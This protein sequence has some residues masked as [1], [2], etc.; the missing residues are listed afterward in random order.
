VDVF[1]RCVGYGSSNILCFIAP[2]LAALV[3]SN[4]YLQDKNSNFLKFLYTRMDKKRYIIVRII[5][6]ALSSRI[7]IVT[8]LIIL[9]MIITLLLGFKT[10]PNSLFKITGL[11]SFLYYKSKWLYVIYFIMNSFIFNV[12]FATL[13]LGLSPFI[14]N[15]YL[16]FLCPFALYTL[17]M[18]LLSYIG[19]SFLNMGL[20]FLSNTAR[21]E[22]FIIT[23]QSILLIIGITLFYLGVLY[24]NEKNL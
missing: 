14:N 12:I 17:S 19:L 24:R 16:S 9:L 23:Y 6:N 10:N 22:I 11:F 1:L 15:K 13:A 7:V 4:S 18:T 2:L 8:S 5:V 21:S 3:F 20:L